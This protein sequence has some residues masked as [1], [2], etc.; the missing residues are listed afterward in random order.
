MP[1]IA[2]V[3]AQGWK[4]HQAGRLD[5]AERIYRHVIGQAPG[6]PEAHVY[7]GIV[8]FDRRRYPDSIEA[9]R[10]ALSIKDAFPIASGRGSAFA[11]DRPVVLAGR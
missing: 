6:N 9:Y 10:K 4:I 11:P 1:T 7:L 2:D 3:L 8:L 5:E